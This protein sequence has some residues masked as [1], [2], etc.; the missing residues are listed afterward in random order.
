MLI[1]QPNSHFFTDLQQ[2]LNCI[3][4]NMDKEYL[5]IGLKNTMDLKYNI[6]LLSDIELKQQVIKER[7]Y[8]AF[9]KFNISTNILTGNYNIK[10]FSMEAFDDTRTKLN[11]EIYFTDNNYTMKIEKEI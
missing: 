4:S 9:I 11:V 6:R 10:E 5:T 2:I 7:L 1:T 8:D 3:N